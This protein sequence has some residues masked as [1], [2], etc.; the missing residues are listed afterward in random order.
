[1]RDVEKKRGSVVGMPTQVSLR[2]VGA[3]TFAFRE[4]RV[5]GLRGVA[6]GDCGGRDA[7]RA[8][9]TIVGSGLYLGIYGCICLKIMVTRIW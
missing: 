2:A 1:M 7:R 3:P 8:I 6:G 4:E 9:L 5:K